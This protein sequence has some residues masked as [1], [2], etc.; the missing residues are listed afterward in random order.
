MGRQRRTQ[1]R[2]R[3]C[4]NGA[5]LVEFALILPVFIMLLLGL[6]SGGFALNEKQQMTHAAREGA[7]YAATISADQEFA[8]LDGDG[9]PDRWAQ[10]VRDL[11]VNRSTGSL[12]SANICVALVEGDSP[13]A[14]VSSDHTTRTDGGVCIDDQFYRDET[15]DVGRRIQVTAEKPATIQL[16]L[17]GAYDVT[18]SVDA[19]ARSEFQP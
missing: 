13:T 16:G 14:A 11:I 19:T 15:D 6:F 9:S 2:R 17:F 3:S 18:L 4:D 1:G 7:R 12:G 10:V 8:D 5:S